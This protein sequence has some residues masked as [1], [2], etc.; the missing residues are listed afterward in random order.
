VGDEVLVSASIGELN[1]AYEGALEEM[2]RTE[3]VAG[4]GS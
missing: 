2:L 1:S 4:D 3:S